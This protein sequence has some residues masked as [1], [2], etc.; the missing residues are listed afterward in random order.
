[1]RT[2]NAAGVSLNPHILRS[3]LEHCRKRQ[4]AKG[5]T[6]I[7]QDDRSDILYYLIQGTLQVSLY[8]ES[9]DQELVIA[10]LSAGDFAGEMGLFGRGHRG[11]GASVQTVTRCTVAEISYQRFRAALRSDHRL[12]AFVTAQLVT[13]LQQSNTLIGELAFDSVTARL[14]KTLLR[15]CK[16]SEALMIPGVGTQISVTRT[17]LGG[18]I[19]ASR[20]RTGKCLRLLEDAGIIRM[21]GRRITVLHACSGPREQPPTPAAEIGLQS[22]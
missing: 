7:H 4:Y 21:D 14:A 20:E 8:C 11:Y 22:A 2:W 15:L 18:Q 17:A 3:L 10:H 9:S 5:A 16:H 1:M 13:R 19:G 12:M 6:L